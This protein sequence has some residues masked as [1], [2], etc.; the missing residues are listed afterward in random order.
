[1]KS[2]GE[3]WIHACQ[4]I[5]DKVNR[6]SE[7]SAT[8][9]RL[10]EECLEME[11]WL[12][13]R[14]IILKRMEAE[15]ASE[16]PK[17]M[18]RI[19]Q[20]KSI[21]SELEKKSEKLIELTVAAE[22]LDD[23][24]VDGEAAGLLASLETSQDR[25]DALK[26]ILEVQARRIRT[27][28]FEIDLNKS[29]ASAVAETSEEEKKNHSESKKRKVSSTRTDLDAIAADMEEWFDCWETLLEESE[30]K[31]ERGTQPKEKH[32][33]LCNEADADFK[34]RRV[35]FERALELGQKVVQD[36]RNRE[37]RQ[38]VQ[39]K[40]AA[41]TSRWNAMEDQL[42]ETNEEKEK[43]EREKIEKIES[44]IWNF[45]KT[46]QDAYKWSE[47]AQR[48]KSVDV[49]DDL[50]VKIESFTKEKEYVTQL[51]NKM[52]INQIRDDDLILIHDELILKLDSLRDEKV[53][54]YVK[55]LEDLMKMLKE[56]YLM[57]APLSMESENR[58]KKFDQVRK[59]LEIH[60][61]RIDKLFS[62]KAFPQLLNVHSRWCEVLSEADKSHKKFQSDLIILKKHNE[63]L[64]KIE[65]RFKVLDNLANQKLDENNIRHRIEDYESQ[66]AE[67]E[68]LSVKLNES[69]EKM[70]EI[71][72]SELKDFLK[73]EVDKIS[74]RTDLL[75][76]YCQELEAVV[77]YVDEVNDYLKWLETIEEEEKKEDDISDTAQL[78]RARLAK[79]RLL[80]K[81]ESRDSDFDKLCRL[82]AELSE[83]EVSNMKLSDLKAKKEESTSKI[84]ERHKQLEK[85]SQQYGEFKALVAQETDWL[86]KLEKR[87][88]KSPESA[89]DAEDISEELDVSKNK[90]FEL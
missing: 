77:K 49:I 23:S 12:G 16:I 11:K 71:A 32:V 28:G 4:W 34:A 82:G 60:N 6:L 83:M 59:S 53:N 44:E 84:K 76:E 46:V 47:E 35:D 89:A 24:E 79:S 40:L 45:K 2:L 64:S 27:S 87:L 1:M 86:D 70:V 72:D 13:D 22:K 55:H 14:E 50:N 63:N 36:S 39:K 38:A 58:M 33:E 61:S 15:P 30:S 19:N 8:Q 90:F 80:E 85:A 88:R 52:D 7:S 5:S 3:R 67:L 65:E 25:L 21:F 75:K 54:D 18:E 37:D 78:A 42:K 68:K 56:E 74:N 69:L 20:M 43:V 31:V 73:N 9:K 81:M 10:E 48:R 57:D 66:I 29:S 41:L 62:M 26:S 51:K 17:I